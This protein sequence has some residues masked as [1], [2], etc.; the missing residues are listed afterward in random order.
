MTNVRVNAI[1]KVEG[2]GA[3]GQVL[4]IALGCEHENLILENVGL[5]RL[6]EFSSAGH[7]VMP[8]HEL[9][10]PTQSLLELLVLAPA[11]LVSPVRRQAELRSLVH[12]WVRIWI[13][14][15]LPPI[16]MTVVCS[17]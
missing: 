3:R 4:D 14:R 17:D 15:G 13:S 1:G 5:D 10:Y 6:D 9:P 16:H 11:L 2:R 12:L 8:F 7:V